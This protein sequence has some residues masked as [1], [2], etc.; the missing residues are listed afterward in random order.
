MAQ[1]TELADLD[2]ARRHRTARRVAD[3]ITAVA[4]GFAVFVLV[5]PL[6]GEAGGCTGLLGHAVPCGATFAGVA[7]GGTTL[8]VGALL[9]WAADRRQRRRDH[10]DATGV[11]R[12][13]A[14]VGQD[15]TGDGRGTAG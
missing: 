10:A 14:A 1:H 12:P 8:V 4:A 3:L 11:G 2:R 15:R 13:Q 7:A 9:V 6:P 5:N